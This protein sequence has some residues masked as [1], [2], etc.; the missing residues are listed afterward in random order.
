MPHYDCFGDSW[1]PGVTPRCKYCGQVATLE[2]MHHDGDILLCDSARCHSAYVEEK[3]FGID[4]WE[5][6]ADWCRCKA[7][8]KVWVMVDET[9]TECPDCSSDDPEILDEAT[10]IARGA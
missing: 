8:G 1:L 4:Y 9:C 7:C 5:D 3:G 10:L 6:P 2:M